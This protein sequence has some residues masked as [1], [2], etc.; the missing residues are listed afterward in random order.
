[1]A[2]ELTDAAPLRLRRVRFKD[3]RTV[4]V[5]RRRDDG[6]VGDR[7]RKVA[8]QAIENA[9]PVVG[10]ALVAWYEN[11]EVFPAFHN[12]RE[13]PLLAGQVPQYAKDVLLAEV[14]AR[15]AKDE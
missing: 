2:G 12:G 15:W 7:L 1:M 13:S 14:A 11:G 10:Y 8:S 4:E 6:E 9:S 5:L 3:G